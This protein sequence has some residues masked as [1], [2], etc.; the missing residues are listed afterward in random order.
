LRGRCLAQMVMLFGGATSSTRTDCMLSRLMIGGELMLLLRC[1]SVMV[2][3][4]SMVL[5]SAQMIL[6][7]GIIVEE[8]VVRRYTVILSV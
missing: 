8:Q 6:S 5:A 3:A 7:V 4:G 1:R 2:V